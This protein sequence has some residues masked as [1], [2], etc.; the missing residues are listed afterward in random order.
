MPA[1]IAG[2]KAG[3]ASLTRARSASIV[4][5]APFSAPPWTEIVDFWPFLRGVRIPPS[6]LKFL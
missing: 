6:P 3:Q 5:G 2:G 4:A 1:L